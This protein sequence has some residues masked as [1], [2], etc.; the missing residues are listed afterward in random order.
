MRKRVNMQT[1]VEDPEAFEALRD[2][3]TLMCRNGLDKHGP[4]GSSFKGVDHAVEKA[5]QF[6]GEGVIVLVMDEDDEG[7]EWHFEP[8]PNFETRLKYGWQGREFPVEVEV[9]LN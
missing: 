4:M 5:M 2:I 8:G 1:V 6:L 7:E 9:N 3:V